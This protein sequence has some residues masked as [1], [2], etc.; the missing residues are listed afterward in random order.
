[1]ERDDARLDPLGSHCKIK[2]Y[3]VDTLAD[4]TIREKD[5]DR[6]FSISTFSQ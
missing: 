2:H 3:V 4:P 1:V 5:E 6:R